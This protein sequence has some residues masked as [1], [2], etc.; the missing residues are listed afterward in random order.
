MVDACCTKAAESMASTNGSGNSNQLFI[1]TST[2][3][4]D[5]PPVQLSP[6][7]PQCG[8]KAM[9]YDL[10]L[11]GSEYLEHPT[12]AKQFMPDPCDGAALVMAPPTVAAGVVTAPPSAGLMGMGLLTTVANSTTALV[13][14]GTGPMVGL[15]LGSFVVG[16]SPIGH[17]IGAVGVN[18]TITMAGSNS[19]GGN[20]GGGGGRAAAAAAVVVPSYRMQ[21]GK[22]MKTMSGANQQIP[23]KHKFSRVVKDGEDDERHGRVDR[24]KISTV[25]AAAAADDD[26]DEDDNDDDDDDDS[27]TRSNKVVGKR[28]DR[29]VKK[30]EGGKEENEAKEEEEGDE[31]EEE[32]KEEDEEE[33]Y[34]TDSEAE[35]YS[36]DNKV[37]KGVT[38]SA[39]PQELSAKAKSMARAFSAPS[40]SA[41]AAAAAAVAVMAAAAQAVEDADARNKRHK[42][43]SPENHG[44]STNSDWGSTS[45]HACTWKGC[46]KTYAKSSHLKAHL[47]RHT[48]EKPFQCTWAE[49]DWRFSRSDELAR[50]LRSHTGVKPFVCQVCNKSF[51]RSDHLNKHVRIHKNK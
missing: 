25:A 11:Y 19:I 5:L 30:E 40:H 15:G 37:A 49:C 23:R 36:G 12:D 42:T 29:G 39:A 1:D 50:H 14:G 51:S 32:G 34:E 44:L 43:L 48:G 31:E 45:V 21:V 47:R 26:D 18:D 13:G 28:A 24:Y 8:P 46:T 17:V 22:K 33:D 41:S 38:R 27:D 6:W 9:P 4:S 16:I 20:G 10:T 7:V 35:H 3:T 2:D